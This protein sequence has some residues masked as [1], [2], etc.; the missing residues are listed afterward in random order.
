MQATIIPQAG[1]ETTIPEP[2]R[3]MERELR[4]GLIE[5]PGRACLETVFGPPE[6]IQLELAVDGLLAPLGR[7]RDC[8]EADWR[9]LRRAAAQ[10][11][12]GLRRATDA[13]GVT[14]APL[15]P[16]ET[17][18]TE[19]VARAD[20]LG[21]AG[22]NIAAVLRHIE[23]HIRISRLWEGET[24]PAELF[25]ALNDAPARI[26]ARLA[27]WRAWSDRRVGP[28][29]CVQPLPDGRCRQL[30][31]RFQDRVHGIHYAG[32]RRTHQGIL[33]QGLHAN[34]LAVAR[35]ALT[36]WD[37]LRALLHGAD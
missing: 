17:A 20:A 25:D 27:D 22:I 6:S 23:L 10:A 34:E 12:F 8:D 30:G 2:V 29:E 26:K 24:N 37:E 32:E 5:R 16:A 28:I 7:L 9:R 31:Y 14:P 33:W 36:T 18:V 21:P 3:H 11:T 13:L 19:A 4:R 35:S 15:A 1:G